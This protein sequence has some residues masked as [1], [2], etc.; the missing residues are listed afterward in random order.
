MKGL[1]LAIVSSAILFSM[2]AFAAKEVINRCDIDN[3][4]VKLAEALYFEA[5]GESKKGIIAVGQVI[6]N[7][8]EST[9]FKNTVVEVVEQKK[10]NGSKWVCQFS[11]VCK[12]LNSN[13][14]IKMKKERANQMKVIAR[15]VLDG[16][17]PDY[18]NGADHFIS[19]K[20]VKPGWAKKMALVS[21]IGG[22]IFFDSTKKSI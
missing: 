8:T 22:H 12:M 15:G 20:I 13:K 9:S 5:R 16:I 4:C 6:I 7:R 19:S 17:Y 10:W 18:S 11:Y 3:N 14:P 1:K 2:Q 21:D